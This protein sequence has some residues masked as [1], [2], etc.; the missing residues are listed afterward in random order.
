MGQITIVCPHCDYSKDVDRAR[1]P[2]R[3][4]SIRCPSCQTSFQLSDLAGAAVPPAPAP[5][6]T[7]PV[8][9]IPEPTPAQPEPRHLPFAFTGNAREYFG[10]WIVN[11]LLKI[12]TFGIY[13]PWAKV[14]SRQYFYGNTL[15]EGA[16]FDYLA[17]P[18]ALLKGWLLGAALFIIYTLG[19]QYSPLVGMGFGLLVF[20]LIPWVI[21]RSRLFNNRNS[22]H[23]NIRFNFRPA[24]AESYKVF[25]GLPLL[26][27]LTLGLLTPYSYYRQKRFLMEN[28]SFGQS[29]FGFDAR[30][31]D[32][33]LVFL[34]IFGLVILAL[35]AFAGSTGALASLQ[36]D[37][38]PDS[39]VVIGALVP[40]IILGFFLGYF[41]LFIYSYVRISNLTWNGTHLGANRFI[42]TM[43]VRD[44]SWIMFT[45]VLASILSVGL[46]VPWAS[47]R[48][49]RYR[50]S[51]LTLYCAGDLDHYLNAAVE[52]TSAAGEEIG[53]IFGVDLGF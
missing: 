21:V 52:P 11:T 19:S 51:R 6:P 31:G 23:R 41:L 8:A 50:L 43:R 49:A 22:A 10:I 9:V 20:L 32:F 4:K 44:M 40:V 38:S 29:P 14:R 42:S 47:V 30:I 2:A 24:Y 53:D 39:D 16:N 13:S 12:V 35:I 15:L 36:P 26:S 3:V 27:I 46:L 25:A 45:N 17:N 48:L 37:F 7:A 18:L 5:E 1:I 34:K 33:Y 28:N